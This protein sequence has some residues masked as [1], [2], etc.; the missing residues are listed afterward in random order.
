M[1]GPSILQSGV[2]A[3]RLQP[4]SVKKAQQSINTSVYLMANLT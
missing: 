3:E 1:R 4:N 2:T